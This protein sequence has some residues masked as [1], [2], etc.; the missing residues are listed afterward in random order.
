MNKLLTFIF[1]LLSSTLASSQAVISQAD[2]D[3]LN[4]SKMISPLTEDGIFRDSAYYHWGASIIKGNDGLYHLF[5]SRW[6]KET[7]FRGW[8]TASEIAHAVSQSASGPWS[9]KETVLKGRGE[10]YWDAVTAHNPKIKYFNGK[11]YLY[12]IATN[13]GTK[14]GQNIDVSITRE[15]MIDNTTW[16]ILRQNQRTGV[17]ISQSVNGPWERCNSPLI[18]PE[19][20]IA[21]ITINPAIALGRDGVYHLI[22]K[23]DKPNEKKFIRNQAIAI[24][25]TPTGPFIMLDEPVIGNLDTED[26]SMWYD[27]ANARF[28]AIFHAHTFIGLMTSADGLK[29]GKANNY[30]ITDKKV[31]LEDGSILKPDR[32]ERPFIYVENGKPKVLSLAIKK[33]DDS[34]TIFIPLLGN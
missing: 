34:Y 12:Y 20:P 27:E 17:A 23:G 30:M 19:G 14:A 6:K 24:S 9:Y 26:I 29:W 31:L 22:V 8:L 18:E 21:N 33:G 28:Y 4:L 10:G 15:K 5:Y 7:T 2:N 3:N 32:M 11:Y 1:L 13:T 25:E 16:N